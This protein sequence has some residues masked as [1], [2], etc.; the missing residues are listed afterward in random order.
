MFMQKTLIGCLLLALLLSCNKEVS[1]LP[2][3]T[4][5][6]A[7]TFGANVNG[8]FWEPKRFGIIPA[9]NL[10]EARRNSPTSI[11]INARNFA[12][13]PDESE[14]EI[15]VADVTGPGTYLLNTDVTL[16]SGSSYGYYVKRRTT[17]YNEWLTSAAYTGSVTITRLDTI[18]KIVSGTFQFNAINIYHDPQPLSVTDGRFDIKMQY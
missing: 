4:Q 14:F 8:V 18:N 16:P 6:G 15:M 1:E 11:I 13:E 2:P 3:A 17:P 9:D 5:T 7:N 10:L 12:A